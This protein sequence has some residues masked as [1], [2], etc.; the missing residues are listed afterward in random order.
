VLQLPLW[1]VAAWGDGG[2]CGD[3]CCSYRYGVLECGETEGNV[4]MCAAVTV[5]VCYSVGKRRE[6]ERVTERGF[7]CDRII[8]DSDG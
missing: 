7:M 3:V 6:M 5:M 1:C 8:G 2:K 4:V